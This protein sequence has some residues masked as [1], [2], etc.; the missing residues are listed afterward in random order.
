MREKYKNLI[1][2]IICG[3]LV[4]TMFILLSD[5]LRNK[6]SYKKNADFYSQ[7]ENFDVLFLGSSHMV[8]G[9]SPMEL[10]NSYGIVSYN[11]GNHGQWIPV[12]YWVLKNALD[13]TKPK[14]VVLDVY[15]IDKNEKYSKN[16][17]AF[18]HEVFDIMPLSR[19]KISA[20]C[21]LL[22]EGKRMEFL[23]DFSYYHTRWNEINSTFWEQASPSTQKGAN[24]DNS[25]RSDQAVVSE[26]KPLEIID[27]NRMCI[28]ESTGKEYLRKIIEMC[29]KENMDVLLTALPCVVPE[30]S[31]VWYN[32][33]KAIADEYSI[34]Y[35]D[36][37]QEDTFLNYNTDFYDADH[38]NSSGAKK[39]TKE[40]GEYIVEKYD[41]PDQ[42]DNNIALEWNQDYIDYTNYK[43][44]WLKAQTN[45]DTYLMCLADEQFSCVIQIYDP[46]IWKNP[47]YVHL[48]ENL[49]VDINQI[50]ENTD[51]IVVQEGG[52]STDILEDFF[53]HEKVY[54]TS[55]GKLYMQSDG[56]RQERN[57]NDKS[58][59]IIIDNEEKCTIIP[60]GKSAVG[61]LVINQESLETVDY[62]EF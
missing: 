56:M 22:P 15:A 7:K 35:L 46:E 25:N 12:D 55:I 40:L 62:S 4:F 21:D 32:S 52:K 49:G 6:I 1:S 58:Y 61:I 13:Y 24:L 48:F 43:I 14:L 42:R 30:S 27:K 38:L 19:N 44:D 47:P 54:K 41:L 50:T 53:L 31:Q 51:C 26:I 23:F 34:D 2:V 45:L 28:E 17:I 3:L 59:S 20:L 60:D 29:Q 10:W 57:A 37:N 18:M 5:F 33:T 39:I 11:F 9:I 8:M 36:W 16:H